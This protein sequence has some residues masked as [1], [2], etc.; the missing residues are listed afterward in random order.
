M[1]QFQKDI[2]AKHD[3]INEDDFNYFTEL[4]EQKV[5]EL[6]LK[7]D[8]K[9]WSMFVDAKYRHY[10]QCEYCLKNCGLK[11]VKQ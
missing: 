6:G 9:I 10:H 2:L 8:C 4:S 5:S 11:C 7:Q 3:T 1:N